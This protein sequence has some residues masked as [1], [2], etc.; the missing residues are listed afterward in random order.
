MEKTTTLPLKFTKVQEAKQQELFLSVA[1]LGN[2]LRDN[3]DELNAMNA[4]V[5]YKPTS[6]LKEGMEGLETFMDKYTDVF[7]KSINIS[8]NTD[9]IELQNK[10]EYIIRK[11]YKS[12]IKNNTI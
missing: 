2:L 5:G 8:S 6:V 10:V 3:V 1:V 9:F 12:L 4:K 7:S 11:N